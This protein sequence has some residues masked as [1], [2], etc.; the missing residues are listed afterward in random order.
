MTDILTHFGMTDGDTFPQTGV[1]FPAE[2]RG[3]PFADDAELEALMLAIQAIDDGQLRVTVIH[4]DLDTG[5]I[6]FTGYHPEELDNDG[7]ILKPEWWDFE[8]PTQ[9]AT[10]LQQALGPTVIVEWMTTE[11][12]FRLTTMLKGWDARISFA[13]AG[14]R[15]TDISALL[16][17]AN[18]SDATIVPGRVVASGGA[19]SAGIQFPYGDW[20]FEP[21]DLLNDEGLETPVVLSLFTDALA[22]PDDALPG[23]AEDDRRG[24]WAGPWGSRLW[25]LSREKWTEEVKQR[26]EYYAREALQWMIDDQVVDRVETEARLLEI[27]T[28]AVG[29]AL[30]RDGRLLFSK[31]Y[32]IMWQA[33]VSYTPAITRQ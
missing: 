4:D 22:K 5:P 32:G 20:V 8:T 24:W 2:L 13:H 16:K 25:L 12:F 14:L 33:T 7:G 11:R 21:P 10:A 9:I 29:V 23:I 3:Y 19:T 6:D 18:T 30:Y 15:G 28:I 31:P 27:G 26:A 1:S 17:L